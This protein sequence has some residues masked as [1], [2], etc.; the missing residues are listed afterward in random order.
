MR[1]R[2]T[3]GGRRRG[4]SRSGCGCSS[5]GEHSRAWGWA[6]RGAAGLAGLDQRNA[7]LVGVP[8]ASSISAAS[9][10]RTL[11]F[12]VRRPSPKR[13]NR[14][15]GPSPCGRGP[16]WIGSSP[17]AKLGIEETAAVAEVRVVGA[18]LVAVVAHGQAAGD[19][20]AGARGTWR[21]P[22]AIRRRRTCRGP[23][24]RRRGRCGSGSGPRGRLP[25]APDRRTPGR[26]EEREVGAIGWRN[27]HAFLYPAAKG[28]SR[29]AGKHGR[30]PGA[31]ALGRCAQA[32]STP[33]SRRPTLEFLKTEAAS[34]LI[35]SAVALAAWP[36]RP[37]PRTTSASSTPFSVR[38]ACSSRP[39]DVS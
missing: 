23:R 25:G 16:A 32:R 27:R 29:A 33:L 31:L 7:R 14:A 18:E 17:F 8:A 39:A 2:S 36:T 4:T 6:R 34:G 3:A 30:A 11:P 15:S 24:W 1:T 5:N 12:R 28:L 20:P 13:G 10:S 26:A 21:R 38:I 19:F 37:G 9:T 22:H 35:L